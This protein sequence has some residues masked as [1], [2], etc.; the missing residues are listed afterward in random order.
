MFKKNIY[1]FLCVVFIF[2]MMG[3]V[4][5]LFE[6]QNS[7]FVQAGEYIIIDHRHTDV[8]QIPDQWIAA[9]KNLMIQWVA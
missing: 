7:K 8:S 2:L 4:F 5:S 1:L 9:A 6:F 3:A